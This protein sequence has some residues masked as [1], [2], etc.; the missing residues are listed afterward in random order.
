MNVLPKV[1]ASLSIL[2][3]LY[4][5]YSQLAPGSLAG[6]HNIGC[7]LAPHALN[8]TASLH[9][10]LAAANSELSP[11]L[12]QHRSIMGTGEVA[13]DKQLLTVAH[14]FEKY[15]RQFAKEQELRVQDR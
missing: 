3:G 11:L 15:V 5:L 9:A 1:L 13:F 6:Q 7:Y 4:L 8:H 10:R 2:L 14:S 12:H